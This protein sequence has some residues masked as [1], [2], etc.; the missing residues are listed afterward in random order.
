MER[1]F[2]SVAVPIPANRTY[3]YEVPAE[4]RDLLDVGT[5]VLVNFRGR[6][7]TGWVTELGGEEV[8]NAKAIIEV[9]DP[10]PMFTPAMLKLFRWISSYYLTPIGLVIRAA[11]PKGVSPIERKYCRYVSHPSNASELSG[12]I[13]DYVQERGEK[14][15]LK[16]LVKKLGKES[17]GE[18]RKLARAG[19]LVIE[20]SLI[21][22][23]V[24]VKRARWVRLLA[25]PERLTNRQARVV[26][27]LRKR[28]EASVS[29]VRRVAGIGTS[30]LATLEKRLVIESFQKEELRD[31]L[32][33]LFVEERPLHTLTPA[34][35][36]I[37]GEIAGGMESESP[38]VF[39]LH[40]VTGSGKTEVYLSVIEKALESGKT[41][42]LIV[43]EI[44]LTAQLTPILLERFGEVV[45]E[46]HSGLGAGEQYD[47]WRRIREGSLRVVIGARSALFAP[48]A[49]LGAIVVDE[50]H[51][52]TLKQSDSP[53]RYHARETAI[54]R[55]RYEGAVCLLGGATPSLE[56]YHNAET[57]KYRLLSLPERVEERAL[58]PVTLVDMRSEQNPILSDLLRSKIAERMKREEQ[59]ILFMNRRGYSHFLMCR[60]CGHTP[61]C[62]SCSVTLTYHRT[63]RIVRCHYCGFQKTPPDSCESC[64]G[65]TLRYQGFG[66]QRV[67][68]ELI[69]HFPEMRIVRVDLDTT[70]LKGSHLVIFRK[71]REREADLLLGTQMVAKGLDFPLVTL[72]GVLSA[73][74]SL[75][76]PD[77]RSS[78]RTFQL[79]TQ[80]AGRAGRARLAGEVVV[81]TFAPSH[82]AIDL[83]RNHAYLDFYSRETEERRLLG[84]PPFGRMASITVR[85][86]EASEAA[87]LSADVARRLVGAEAVSVLGP[88]PCALSRIK[89]YHRQRIILKSQKD[90]ALQRVL[91]HR[92]PQFIDGKDRRVVVDI[93][94]VD[95]L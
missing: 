26:D 42:I 95:L 24:K 83:S 31:P 87:E 54:M 60:D 74:S 64:G 85:S 15:S 4:F 23:R 66:T 12:R 22:P 62:P 49:N 33:E 68:E 43:P 48:L 72:V 52:R 7:L 17:L 79:L 20:Q 25:E 93:D 75:N 34:Q 45:G 21:P 80:V 55:A 37:V 86:K 11:I 16:S 28:R 63:P 40:G 53:P 3:S 61:K 76:F 13:L 84:Y 81:Q 70:A 56:S 19:N 2:A 59:T 50:E 51:E 36:Q 92:L 38:P 18:T 88:A 44:F 39:L 78:E 67:E 69:K 73:D 89:G 10:I 35:R 30:T 6:R 8:E 14:V 82:Y 1:Q 90:M 91:S 57:G 27:F 9:V 47:T 65:S 32:K 29:E 77:F 46:Y 5:S 94:P 58:P 71:F 41:A